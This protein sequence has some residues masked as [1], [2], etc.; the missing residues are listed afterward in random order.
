MVFKKPEFCS[1]RLLRLHRGTQQHFSAVFVPHFSTD[2]N[3]LAIMIWLIVSCSGCRQETKLCTLAS[4]SLRF[5]SCLLFAALFYLRLSLFPELAVLK[6]FS[7]GTV[8]EVGTV[9]PE[10]ESNL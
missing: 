1:K 10:D 3:L 8:L 9:L 7:F 4:L 2:A 6:R 5:S